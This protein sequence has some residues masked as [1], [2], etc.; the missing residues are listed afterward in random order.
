[1]RELATYPPLD[2]LEVA[3]RRKGAVLG[4][5]LIY[6]AEVDSTNTLA[7]VLV[8]NAAPIGATV[9]ADHQTAGRGRLQRRWLAAPGSGLTFTV[10][11]GPLA[12]VWAA[13]MNAGLAVADA[14]GA[15]GLAAQL[16]WPNDV[17]IDER[18]CA[19][20][21]IEGKRVGDAYW[22]LAGIGI[23][24]RQ[25]DPDLPQATYVDAHLARPVRREDL[26]VE[27]LAR[28]EG[29]RDAVIQDPAYVRDAWAAQLS[30]IGRAV[31]VQ[32]PQ[33]QFSGLAIG[34]TGDG[35]LRVQLAD[36]RER[37]VQAGDVTLSAR[38]SAG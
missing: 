9:V 16:K 8:P 1:M 20:V 11:L 33:D 12:P 15:L 7:A 24:V 34:I 23:N 6:R 29:W 14:L 10:V 27:V 36:G 38:S 37:V 26:L 13:P 35:A 4:D 18:K 3:R 28:L 22:L 2:S 30:T 17:L 32:G 25:V 19:G 31:T 21:L 5:P